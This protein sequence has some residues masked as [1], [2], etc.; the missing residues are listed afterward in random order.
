MTWAACSASNRP[1][2]SGR[3][4]RGMADDHPITADDV[5]RKQFATSRRGF[6]QNEVRSFLAS[7]AA[8]LASL[9][10]R[11]RSL[12]ER[13][14]AAEQKAPAPELVDDQLEAVLG[15]EMTRVLHAAREAAAEIRAKAEESVARLLREA[16]D[17]ATKLRT[18]AEGI[19]AR[20]TEEADAAGAAILSNAEEA[21]NAL[22]S[23]AESAATATIEEAQT[24]GREMV[25]EA[26]AVRE[27]ILKDLSRRRRVAATQLEQ[28]LAARERLMAA[29]DMVR[30]NLD[31]VTHELSVVESEARLAADVAGFKPPPEDEPVPVADGL[32]P[33]TEAPEPERG[34]AAPEPVGAPVE[35]EAEDAPEPELQSGPGEERRSSSLRLLRRKPD[36][37]PVSVPN[38]DDVEGVRII[39]PEPA[40][41]PPPRPTIVPEAPP[42]PEPEPEPASHDEAS[43]PQ[44]VEDLFARLRAD[45]AAAVAQAEAVLAERLPEA[46]GEPEPEPGTD[47]LAETDVVEHGAEPEA[48]SPE[49]D[50]VFER[51]DA[52]LEPTERGLT[53]ALKRALADEQNEVLDALRRLRGKRTLDALLPSVDDHLARY[54]R[55]SSDHLERGAR[56]GAESV[57]G[58]APEVDEVVDRLAHEIVDD[59]RARIERTL[60]SAG[61]DDEALVEAISATYREWKTAR[62][63]PLAR[64]HLA[65]SYAFGVFDAA[66]AGALLW[67]VD[68][69]EGSCPDCDDNALA[70][71]TPKGT[72]YP[73]GQLH[74]PAHA[75]CRC[76]VLPA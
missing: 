66:D 24:R 64:H 22:R 62:S 36:P 47:D 30:T 72:V 56:A 39:R 32:A 71:P 48:I 29:Y 52:A 41:E 58:E 69:A 5:A 14:D 38:D 16:N 35:A 76:L 2:H 26:Q 7:V 33:A 61:D 27:R 49:Q 17:E 15:T 70:G 11:E 57:S 73:T 51:R 50:S 1:D 18:D 67:T 37:E 55:I 65:A 20:R 63:E 25:A 19:L 9:R 13:L 40:A 43:D 53:R 6:D 8:E 60:D 21:A 46:E 31:E 54:G 34:E 12:R 4:I 68:S 23:E 10:E 3:S 44:P 45:R 75:G 74:P 59:L 42:A 28:L